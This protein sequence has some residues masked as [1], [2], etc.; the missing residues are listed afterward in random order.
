MPQKLAGILARGHFAIGG[1]RQGFDGVTPRQLVPVMIEEIAGSKDVAPGDFAAVGYNHADNALAL[2]AGSGVRKAPLQLVHKVINRNAYGFGLVNLCVRFRAS[3]R[4]D[5]ALDAAR[6]HARSAG[7]GRACRFCF[8][9][10]AA[11]NGVPN[12][13]LLLIHCGIF[14]DAGMDDR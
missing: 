9:V 5:R 12:F 8:Q 1:T 4:S 3:I 14:P 7:W 2:Q 11:A 10:R 13:R 6:G